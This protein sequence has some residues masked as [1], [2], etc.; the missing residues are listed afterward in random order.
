MKL[1]NILIVEIVAGVIATVLITAV[2]NLYLRVDNNTIMTITNKDHIQT[3]K[4]TFEAAL[5]A[6]QAAGDAEI[7]RSTAIDVEQGTEIKDNFVELNRQEDEI[8][9]IDKEV[10]ELGV[11][12]QYIHGK[13]ELNHAKHKGNKEND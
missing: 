8:H 10:G 1:D 12:V 6:Q 9:H 5:A 3:N 13:G 4:T 7:K 2:G 11:A